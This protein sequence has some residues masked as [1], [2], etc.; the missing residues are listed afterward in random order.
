MPELC[1]HAGAF[2]T[3]RCATVVAL[4]LALFQTVPPIAGFRAVHMLPRT[5]ALPEARRKDAA[6][7][8]LP[9]A[10]AA[11]V[12]GGQ[13]APITVHTTPFEL[14]CALSRSACFKCLRLALLHMC[15]IAPR[16]LPAADH[17][18][19]DSELCVARD[20]LCSVAG[21]SSSYLQYPSAHS[22]SARLLTAQHATATAESREHLSSTPPRARRGT[23]PQKR[24]SP[25]QWSRRLR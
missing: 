17:L 21:T 13:E 22:N 20:A 18:H 23:A 25:T 12:A 5:P 7:A 9:A 10:P 15:D 8:V 11:P 6:P 24:T 4:R 2:T 1:M 3:Q 14:R 19:E 16:S